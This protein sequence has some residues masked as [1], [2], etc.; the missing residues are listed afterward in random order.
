[1]LGPPTHPPKGGPPHQHLPSSA[2]EQSDIGIT[3]VVDFFVRYS[4]Q[5]M[6]GVIANSWLAWA[7]LKDEV[8]L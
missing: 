3:D 8:R 2:K 7:Y 4:E 1:M 5:D 6:L